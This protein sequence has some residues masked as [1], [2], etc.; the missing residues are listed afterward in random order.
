MVRDIIGSVVVAAVLEVD[1]NNGIIGVDL[2][3]GS[4]LCL[5]W[6]TVVGEEDVSLLKIVVA[7]ANRRLDLRQGRQRLWVWS[8]VV[9]Y[10]PEEFLEPID[11]LLEVEGEEMSPRDG[12]GLRL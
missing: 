9:T 1:Q 4:F 10:F 6:R 3:R 2:R 11:L 12:F 7:E 5:V 8:W